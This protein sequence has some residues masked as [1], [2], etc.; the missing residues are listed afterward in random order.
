MIGRKHVT[1]GFVRSRKCQILLLVSVSLCEF[2]FRRWER[3]AFALKI[4]LTKK[5]LNGGQF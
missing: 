4:T 2:W 5:E 3:E 1:S